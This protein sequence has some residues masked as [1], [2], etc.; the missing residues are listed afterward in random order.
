MPPPILRGAV[1]GD[2]M[3]LLDPNV[4]IDELRHVSANNDVLQLIAQFVWS[5]E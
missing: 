5:V 3:N 4:T 2:V 1:P